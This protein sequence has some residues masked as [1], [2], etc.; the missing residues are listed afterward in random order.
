MTPLVSAV[1][2]CFNYGRFVARAIESVLG[3]TYTNIECIVVDDGSSDDTCDV[4]RRF[5][6]RIHAISQPHHG[7]SLARNAAIAVARGEFIAFLDGDDYWH[8]GKIEQQL[9]LLTS[10]PELGCVGCG[11]EHVYPD[12]RVEPIAGKV[13]REDPRNTHRNIALRRFWVGG[14]GSGGVVRRAVLD[15]VGLFDETLV[16]AEDWDM[17]L[18]IAAE[19]GIDNVE[20]QLVSINRHGTGVFRNARLMETNQWKVYQKIVDRWPALLSTADKRRLKALILADAARES[21]VRGDAV[22]Y[23]LRSLKEWPF[24]YPRTR[25]AAILTV[26]SLQ[27]AVQGRGAS[28]NA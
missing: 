24:S 16:A 21:P 19:T 3:Q 23:Y 6:G 17:W 22:T 10:R 11:L 12:G 7:V 28:N 20:T 2:P 27:A 4:L 13:N 18:R 9:G 8:P 15:R 5:S 25:A 26:R 14:S 1:I